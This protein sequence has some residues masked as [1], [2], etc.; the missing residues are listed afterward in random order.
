M[1]W[2]TPHMLE[3]KDFLD[4]T[5]SENAHF[6]H[7]T[8]GVLDMK[9]RLLLPHDP[10]YYMILTTKRPYVARDDVPEEDMIRA[11]KLMLDNQE[12]GEAKTA[13]YAKRLA[14][15]LTGE[16]ERNFNV[17]MGPNGGGGKGFTSRAC[18]A[19]FGEYARETH[20]NTFSLTSNS[21]DSSKPR[22][23][24][25]DLQHARLLFTSELAPGL[26]LDGNM[27]K[28]LTG[29][30][31]ITEG[32]Q[33][34]CKAR[35]FVPQFKL[36]LCCN[37]M[38]PIQPLDRPTT[39]RLDLFVQRVEWVPK[40]F[41]NPS[42]PN[43]RL[44]DP[45]NEEYIRTPGFAA[46]WLHILLDY[47]ALWEQ[48]GYLAIADP[49]AAEWV[50]QYNPLQQAIEENFTV[51]KNTGDKVPVKAFNAAVRKVKGGAGLSDKKIKCM[52]KEAHLGLE[53][54]KSN[55]SMFWRGIAYQAFPESEL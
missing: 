37:D 31:K 18:G 48:E 12:L 29:G 15:G 3:D 33:L 54:A 17:L 44:Q 23:K 26:T 4:K 11:R 7:F 6:M 22:P 10:K 25:A 13:E 43:H 19:A 42:N 36:F 49:E 35:L 21:G 53:E 20:A 1:L 51:T 39:V 41:F 32:R 47:L 38:P 8:N 14:R 30:D 52:V 40:R 27:L 5:D 24:L 9:R 46:A 50:E 28:K 34:Y 2:Y 16:Q 55:G 45:S